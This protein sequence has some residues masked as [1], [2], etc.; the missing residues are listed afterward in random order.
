MLFQFAVTRLRVGE[1]LLKQIGRGQISL[2]LC[3]VV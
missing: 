1:V 3:R 2:D